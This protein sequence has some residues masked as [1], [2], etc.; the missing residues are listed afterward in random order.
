MHERRHAHGVFLVHVQFVIQKKLDR[1]NFSRIY[2]VQQRRSVPSILGVRIRLVIQQ[3]PGHF[4]VAKDTLQYYPS[5]EERI[6]GERH[7]AYG[8]AQQGQFGE[9][10]KM[11]TAIKDETKSAS[12]RLLVAQQLLGAGKL[13]PAKALILEAAALLANQTDSSAEYHTRSLIRLLAQVNERGKLLEIVEA[14]KSPLAKGRRTVAAIEGISLRIN[15][16]NDEE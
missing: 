16:R 5:A 15:P 4:D 7:L 2:C 9:A 13:E 10:T 3:K 12:A 8:L 1:F 14:A 11:A 6:S